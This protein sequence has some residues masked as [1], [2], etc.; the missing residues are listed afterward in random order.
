VKDGLGRETHHQNRKVPSSEMKLILKKK[1]R[2]H[3]D[4][5]I[6]ISHQEPGKIV[7]KV[8]QDNKTHK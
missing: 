5:E 8:E 2:S 1:S 4:F 3:I 6:G 7:V